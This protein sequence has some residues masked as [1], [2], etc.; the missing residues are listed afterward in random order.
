MKNRNLYRTAAIVVVSLLVSHVAK[1]DCQGGSAAG[2]LSCAANNA[3]SQAATR[4]AD[5]VAKAARRATREAETNALKSRRL[6]DRA[7]SPPRQIDADPQAQRV[8]EQTRLND[9]A[10]QNAAVMA[11]QRRE[12]DTVLQRQARESDI[13]AHVQRSMDGRGW[14][15]TDVLNTVN[16]PSHISSTTMRDE[17]PGTA[18]FDANNHYVARNNESGTIWAVSNRKMPVSLSDKPNHFTI[19]SRIKNPPKGI[20]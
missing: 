10:T 20:E 2:R 15:K 12:A 19:D 3:F 14:T 7:A 8:L 16:R 1:A 13:A 5:D 11:A 9:Q 18:Y 6:L 4:Q 17:S